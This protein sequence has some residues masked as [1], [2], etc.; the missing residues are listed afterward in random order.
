MSLTIL[1]PSMINKYPTG[2]GAYCLGGCDPVNS[3]SLDSCMPA[4][5]CKNIDTKFGNAT[6]D[7]LIT[8]TSYLGDASTA[9]WVY[10]G[11]PLYTSDAM[12]LTMA[13]DTVGTLVASA[14]YVWYGK[15][16]A[17]M[18]TGRGQGVVTAFILL[19]D[20][21]DEI[22][23][24]FVGVELET[25]QTNYYYQGI[26]NYTHSTNISLSDT[27]ANYHNYTIDWTPDAVTWYVD[28][29]VGRVL[30]K[31]STWNATANQYYFPQTPARV[32]LSIWPGGLASNAPGTIEWAGGEIDWSSQYMQPQGYYYASF[33]EVSITCYD[34]PSGANINGNTSYQYTN[35]AGTNSSVEI[36]D[37]GTKM[38]NFQDTGLNPD[39]SATASASTASGTAD[40]VPGL[41]GAGSGNNGLQ[42]ASGA[43][44]VSNPSS[45]S[46]SGFSQGG[47]ATSGAVQ[48]LPMQSM[49]SG[50]LFLGVSIAMGVLLL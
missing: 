17:I 40:S 26:P 50:S 7:R 37:K 39:P 9:D 1:D 5:V 44:A 42:G 36:T 46:V 10:E 45:T 3:F 13:E 16:T 47:G 41:S 6:Q 30:N 31:S 25:A 24:E 48:N 4:P 2:V 19:S 21:K 27:F 32:Q 11:T 14:D 18:S 33:K 49:I 15:I 12:L 29:Q 34:P 20:V 22:D 8:T 43:G 35:D 23:Y 28:G 38:G